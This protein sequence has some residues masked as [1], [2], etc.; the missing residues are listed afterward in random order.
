MKIALDWTPNPMHTGLFVARHKGW[1]DLECVS[2]SAD[3]YAV[4]PTEKLLRGD[5]DFCIGPPEGLI[6]HYLA[7]QTPQL[8][9]VAPILR[10]NT[11]AF[12]AG[13]ASGIR[14]VGDW[15][16][17]RYAA[18]EL[19]FEKGLLTAI[20]EGSGENGPEVF[21]PAKLD[22]WKML[23]AGETDLT[24]IFLPVEGA[25]AAYE[26]I[27]LT[28][29]QPEAFGIPYPPCPVIHTSRAFVRAEPGA[30]GHFLEGASR[31]YRFAA[32]YPEEAAQL[33]ARYL[34]ESVPPRKL[35]YIQRAV[36]PYYYL[37][38]GPLTYPPAALAAYVDWLWQ[39]GLLKKQLNAESMIWQP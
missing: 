27:P 16:G 10:E 37:T 12:V 39:R 15:P 33:L 3:G 38:A 19:P 17:K 36:N 26:G 9:A 4:M 11:S 6:E 29:F 24:W 5:V 32:D 23:L 1:L 25:E 21:A 8:L 13:P 18:L 22:T 31:G 30:I 14:S 7:E 35:A 2:P 34:E 28:V 20:T